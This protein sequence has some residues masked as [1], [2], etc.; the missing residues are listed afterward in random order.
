MGN[1]KQIVFNLN[2]YTVRVSDDR[3]RALYHRN[4]GSFL[5]IP[6]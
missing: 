5:L 3:A 6:V 4:L 2:S 1:I